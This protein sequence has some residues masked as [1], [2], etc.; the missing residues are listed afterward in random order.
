MLI[1][2]HSMGRKTER[3]QP[4]SLLLAGL[5]SLGFHWPDRDVCAGPRL[6]ERLPEPETWSLSVLISGKDFLQFRRWGGSNTLLER[7]QIESSWCICEGSFS[8]KYW[9]QSP[10]FLSFCS[11]VSGGWFVWVCFYS[12]HFLEVQRYSGWTQLCFHAGKHLHKAELSLK[13]EQHTK[14]IPQSPWPETNPCP[15]LPSLTVGLHLIP[16][17]SSSS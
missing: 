4:N 6:E 14:P 15:E 12:I 8:A 1:L 16:D 11:F 3:E 2:W 5:H 9:S 17:K 7:R 10:G 13:W